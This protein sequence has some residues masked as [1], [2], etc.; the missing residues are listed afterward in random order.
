MRSSF[1]HSDKSEFAESA[2]FVHLLAK[3]RPSEV[4]G[5]FTI[6]YISNGSMERTGWPT[7]LRNASNS[8]GSSVQIELNYL[9]F[10]LLNQEAKAHQP[11]DFLQK[12]AIR[13][14]EQILF[15][16]QLG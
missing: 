9:V 5:L 13:N 3:K 10:H 12:S 4:D 2:A 15:Q 8:S 7:S 1:R 14:P 6:Y 16:S 11:L